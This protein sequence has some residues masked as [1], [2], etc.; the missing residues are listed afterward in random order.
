[1]D[2]ASIKRKKIRS[3][4][5]MM[6]GDHDT[7]EKNAPHGVNTNDYGEAIMRI[8]R[9]SDKDAPRGASY[10]TLKNGAA[11]LKPPLLLLLDF[12]LAGI[13]YIMV[14]VRWCLGVYKVQINIIS[15]TIV[16]GLCLVDLFPVSISHQ[17]RCL[18]VDRLH[19]KE[20]PYA[21]TMMV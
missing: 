9:R 20:C 7:G 1:M 6:S 21:H 11:R 13:I 4:D 14:V 16:V 8:L 19:G 3:W 18:A 10:N 15:Y 12:F 5:K 17:N 2:K